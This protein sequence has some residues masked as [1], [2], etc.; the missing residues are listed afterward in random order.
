[1]LKHQIVCLKYIQILSVIPHK[2]KKKKKQN[3][4]WFLKMNSSGEK[5]KKEKGNIIFQNLNW[6]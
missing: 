4:I 2:D 1:M 5:R 6:L 3:K